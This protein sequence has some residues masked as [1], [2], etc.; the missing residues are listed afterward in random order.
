MYQYC[1]YLS[2]VTVGAA[3]IL[4]TLEKKNYNYFDIEDLWCSQS[5]LP[6]FKDLNN[7][8]PSI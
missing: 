4:G 6:I 8:P 2:V 3:A 7:W 1:P 5:R